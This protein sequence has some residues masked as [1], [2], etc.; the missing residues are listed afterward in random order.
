[1]N[2]TFD[3][4]PEGIDKEHEQE[5]PIDPVHVVKEILAQGA[6]EVEIEVIAGTNAEEDDEASEHEASLH[7]FVAEV[8]VK[9][10]IEVP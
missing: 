2:D 5:G 1:M 7:D 4:R 6:V 3:R 9:Q 8:P 10:N